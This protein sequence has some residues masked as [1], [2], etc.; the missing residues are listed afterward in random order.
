MPF[1]DSSVDFAVSTLSLHHWA[2]TAQVFREIQRVLKP[3]GRFV[4]MDLR[5]DSP[6]WMYLAFKVG[7]ALF[8]PAAIKRT[9]GAVGSFWAAYTPAELNTIML[10]AG[11]REFSIG[12][13]FGWM[14]V[15]GRSIQD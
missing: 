1:A 11:V 14:M 15:Q 7:Q 6:R 10:K 3:G 9:N 4:I 2:D 5:R 13:A 8:A 12:K